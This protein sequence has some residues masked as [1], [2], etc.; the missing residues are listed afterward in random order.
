MFK[1]V[2]AMLNRLRISTLLMTVMGLSLLVVVVLGGTAYHFLNQ[3][4]EMVHD[5]RVQN[6][7]QVQIMELNAVTAEARATLMLVAH[8]MREAGYRGDTDLLGYADQELE[9]VKYSIDLADFEY[10]RFSGIPAA[11][12]E[13]AALLEKVNTHYVR[14]MDE[15]LFSLIDALEER[16][17]THFYEINENVGYVRAEEFQTVL[18]AFSS[19][20]Q[21]QTNTSIQQAEE[22]TQLAILI[23]ISSVVLGLL[24]TLL[25]RSVIQHS[26]I[27]PVRD[28]G[29]LFDHI[30]NG[31]LSRQARFDGDNEI[32]FLYTSSQRMQNSLQAMVLQ[33][34]QSA[35]QIHNSALEL[36]SGNTELNSRMEQSA[37]A[38]QQT[39]ST[40]S[41]IATTVRHNTDNA[42]EADRVTKKAADVAEKGGVAV[43][44]VVDTM[45]D[46]NKSSSQITDFVNVIDSI[47]FQTNILALNA[48]VEAARAGEQG[49][50]FAV[51]ASEVRALAQR[52]AQAAREVKD[53]ID[54]SA[55][56]IKAGSDRAANA[57]Q[58]I[59]QVVQAINSASSI[60]T[61]ISRA[62]DEQSDGVN[63]VNIAVT[64]MD[65]VVQQNSVLVGQ[66][67]D[68]AGALQDQAQHLTAAVAQFT[69]TETEEHSHF[70]NHSTATT[71]VGSQLAYH[72]D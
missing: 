62:S 50:G 33:V 28:L 55:Q 19:Y 11:T 6:Q 34:R 25:I 71:P 18:R 2:I 8:Q 72:T 21:E 58:V 68:L 35:M 29:V 60:M 53:L 56:Q 51:V 65:S 10:K 5:L 41:E 63:Q 45:E 15:V 70:V 42:N 23:I 24:F 7:R 12:D 36:F 30:A 66:L 37:S 39:A 14:Y 16:N 22:R 17:Y 47:A 4:G 13:E 57:G 20:I 43:R 54:D 52:S 49:R 26:I 46:I 64:Q 3:N 31:D 27:R 67:T 40:M 1:K 61:D 9:K 44:T 69:V 38:L 48:A 59:T 32:G